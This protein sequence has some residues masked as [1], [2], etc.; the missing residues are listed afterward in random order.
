MKNSFTVTVLNTSQVP[1]HSTSTSSNISWEVQSSQAQSV[2]L[3]LHWPPFCSQA[4]RN[5]YAYT[6][7]TNTNS[8]AFFLTLTNTNRTAK[9]Q[10]LACTYATYKL[11]KNAQYWNNNVAY[12]QNWRNSLQNTNRTAIQ[13]PLT[14]L[15]HT[16]ISKIS[17]WQAHLYVTLDT[18]KKA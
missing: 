13:V 18:D 5:L 14:E 6:A 8:K 12:I 9:R 11:N 10:R 15:Q 2:T 17:F 4:I 3:N 1:K 16:R 7:S